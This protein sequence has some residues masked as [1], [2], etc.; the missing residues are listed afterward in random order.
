MNDATHRQL[1]L[2]RHAKAEDPE[3]AVDH[4]RSLTDRGRADAEAAGKWLRE[5]GFAPDLVLCSTSAR[6][7]ETWAGVVEASGLGT[8]VEHDPRIYNAPVERLLTVVREADEDAL[9]VV[10]VGHAPGVPD[11]AVELSGE[12]SEPE[13]R[14][15]LAHGFPTCTLAVLDIDT[16]WRDV[17]PGSAVLRTVI[18]P[19]G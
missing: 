9:A 16:P 7:R 11:L 2:L 3:A 10:L 18:T 6:T 15:E 4:E 17:A 12:G 19:R 14:E 5:Q 1:V 13:A 8:V